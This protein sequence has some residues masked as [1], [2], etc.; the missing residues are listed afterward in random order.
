[1]D[2]HGY[3]CRTCGNPLELIY[4]PVATSCSR[5]VRMRQIC[6]NDGL[7]SRTALVH[8]F[9]VSVYVIGTLPGRSGNSASTTGRALP[10]AAAAL[11]DG[12]LSS[13]P[14]L[15]SA[16]RSTQREVAP[17]YA[18]EGPAHRQPPLA[19]AAWELSR[20]TV[21]CSC[22][23]L[24]ERPGR[25]APSAAGAWLQAQ[26]ARTAAASSAGR[27]EHWH[28]FSGRSNSRRRTAQKSCAFGLG[29][30]RLS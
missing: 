17:Q 19:A 28:G 29:R 13:P 10:A 5:S 9:T 26:F 12:A 23:C 16:L 20:Q 15:S 8:A 22:S 30:S 25:A 18:A 1:M 24:P 2:Y 7:S 6:L 4:V 21:A 3:R 11:D 14:W 27:D